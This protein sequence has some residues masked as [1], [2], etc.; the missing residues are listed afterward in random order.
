M[1]FCHIF[2]STKRSQHQ[3]SYSIDTTTQLSQQIQ[4]DEVTA[5]SITQLES[6]G[7][8]RSSVV[9]GTPTSVGCVR[10]HLRILVV[11][12]GKGVGL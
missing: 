2:E 12:P 4:R 7:P 5:R 9:L 11:I 6:G 3:C 1:P 10:Q 8:Y